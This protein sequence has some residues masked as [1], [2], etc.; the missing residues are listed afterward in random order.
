MEFESKQFCEKWLSFV[1]V[2]LSQTIYEHETY[3]KEGKVNGLFK[4]V[5]QRVA[6]MK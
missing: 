2:F 1:Y 5:D 3:L 6:W 4:E